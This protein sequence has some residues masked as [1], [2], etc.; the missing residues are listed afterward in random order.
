MM[1]K[2][3]V[4]P[5]VSGNS[6]GI[7]GPVCSSDGDC[8]GD[9]KCCN[10][11]CGRTCMNP[12]NRPGNTT[13]FTNDECYNGGTCFRFNCECANGY[14]GVFC[15]NYTGTQ[16]DC[17]SSN[18]TCYNGGSCVHG[19]DGQYFCACQNYYRGRSCEILI[20]NTTDV[21]D[22][23]PCMNN[24]T[25]VDYGYSSYGCICPPGTMGINCEER[26]C[27]YFY[28]NICMGGSCIGDMRTGEICQ[29]G[30]NRK[31][32]FCEKQGYEFIWGCELKERF[33]AYIQK[34]LQGTAVP[35][36]VNYARA[37]NLIEILQKFN[38][39]SYIKP[40]CNPSNPT[41][42]ISPT[43]EV[44]VLTGRTLCFCVDNYGFIRGNK[45]SQPLTAA[46]CGVTNNPCQ[47]NP[48]QNNF[49]CINLGNGSHMC[50]CPSSYGPNCED[51]PIY[52]CQCRT[53]KKCIRKERC[54]TSGCKETNMCVDYYYRSPCDAM[55][56]SYNGQCVERAGQGFYCNC[57]EGYTGV[58]CQTNARVCSMFGSVNIC[59]AG[60]CVG[61]VQNGMLCKCPEGRRGAFCERLGTAR[62]QCERQ[63]DLTDTVQR[64]LNGTETVPGV[65]NASTMVGSIMRSALGSSYLPLTNCSVN[66]DFAPQQ[67]QRDIYTG[68]ERCYCVNSRGQEISTNVTMVPGQPPCTAPDPTDISKLICSALSNICRNGGSC[69]GEMDRTPRLCLCPDGYEGILCERRSEPGDK[70]QNYTMCTYSHESYN[71]MM[72]ILNDN[73]T[74]T[75]ANITINKN[76][77]MSAFYQGAISSFLTDSTNSTL[78]RPVM[79]ISINGTTRLAVIRPNCTLSGEFAP[80]QCEYFL[81]SGERHACY[82]YNRAGR[83]VPGTHTM[84]PDYPRCDGTHS[85]CENT[86]CS[87][88]CPHGLRKD[89]RGC[90]VCECRKPCDGVMCGRGLRCVGSDYGAECRRTM[91]AW[92]MPDGYYSH[93]GV[94]ATDVQ[95]QHAEL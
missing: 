61:D 4:C 29:C 62:T 7:C 16:G 85:E 15:Q 21:C 23:S 31:G 65:N 55:P 93:V 94:S 48:C 34:V 24:G 5:P 27:D 75:V 80:M 2:P 88:D 47:S 18:W 64:I 63:Q 42:Y 12:Y 77:L 70:P 13:C 66:G 53:G 91:E 44:D 68:A 54:G 87:L 60:E 81:D 59:G 39:T 82:C 72:A 41:Q 8:S 36:P 38:L 86:T 92:L 40:K 30:S 69:V 67:C 49:S 73:F 14:S 6:T 46:D 1:K 95:R 90:F 45:T 83:V 58:H 32:L 84:A 9:S 20:Q 3:G 37:N 52:M 79:P 17:R 25:C 57:M 28:S 51:V 74:L 22:S 33:S 89:M 76:T 26:L 50:D 43:C 56:C 35:P 19:F 78:N 71:M 11:G 10:N